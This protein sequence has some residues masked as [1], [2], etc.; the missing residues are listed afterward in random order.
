MKKPRNLI[1]QRRHPGRNSNPEPPEYKSASLPLQWPPAVFTPQVSNRRWHCKG[2]RHT[3]SAQHHDMPQVQPTWS[4]K[5]SNW[6]Q[7]RTLPWLPKT[8][9]HSAAGIIYVRSDIL[10]YCLACSVTDLAEI[11]ACPLRVFRNYITSISLIDSILHFFQI[12]TPLCAL[13][14]VSLM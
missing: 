13:H 10:L 14:Y 4:W 5:L 6:T 2:C 3:V 11:N 8:S 12:V 7:K 1:R 9:E